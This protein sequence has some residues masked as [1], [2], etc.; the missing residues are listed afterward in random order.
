MDRVKTNRLYTSRIRYRKAAHPLRDFLLL[1]SPP[2][3]LK[4]SH[5][6][7]IKYLK[8]NISNLSAFAQYAITN[9]KLKQQFVDRAKKVLSEGPRI[10]LKCDILTYQDALLS[11]TVLFYLLLILL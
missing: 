4:V 5:D 2:A 1:L 6:L 11:R 10:S 8:N 9:T 3:L 7:T